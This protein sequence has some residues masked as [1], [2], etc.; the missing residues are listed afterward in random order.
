MSVKLPWNFYLYFLLSACFMTTA[1]LARES[2]D[3][4]PDITQ[5][6]FTGINQLY[7]LNFDEAEKTF[8]SVS[9]SLSNNPVGCVYLGITSI[10]RTLTEGE[11][12]ENT[13]R[14]HAYTDTA[15]ARALRSKTSLKDSWDLYYS[16]VAFLLKSYS[17]GKKQNYIESLKW[18][19]RGLALINRCV[20]REETKA[21][22]KMLIGAYR[23]FASRMPWYFK[24]FASLL[25]EP[26]DR[27]EG[28]CDLE[29]AVARS[30]FN[31]T[32]AEL[33]LS[34]AY[35]WDARSE[36]AYQL[37]SNLLEKYPENYCVG[38]LTQEILLRQ[39]KYNAALDYATN[40]FHKI[41]FDKRPVT[42]GL[43]A[44][45]HYMLGLIYERKRKYDAALKNFALAYILAKNKPYLKAWAILRQ[46][47]IY[48]LKNDRAQAR[49]CY[50]VVRMTDHK[51]D[52]LNAFGR[53]FSEKPYRGESLE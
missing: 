7:N 51:S 25:V 24:F 38:F 45:Q 6:I 42:G 17:E 26:A 33:F 2:L 16:G 8:T 18:L 23:Y 14:F 53:R 10:G 20:E 31:R 11:T 43:M 5:K 27:A 4:P 52:L 48:D 39:K 28:L 50:A 30:K 44:N 41:E 9:A 36:A 19:K 21:D 34:I 32:E 13:A 49:N 40:Q 22:A 12:K 1:G 37:A 3:F 15:V 46:G 29:F 35:M 47:T